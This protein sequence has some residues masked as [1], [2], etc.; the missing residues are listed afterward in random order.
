MTD[1]GLYVVDQETGELRAPGC[2]GCHDLANKLAARER[3]IDAEREEITRL[4]RKIKALETDKEAKMRRDKLFLAAQELFDEWRTECGHP[5]AE[6][7][8]ARIRLALAAVRRYG[9]HR[10]KLSWVI[11]AGKHLAYVNEQGEKQ[12][13]FGLLFRD[14]EHIEMYA[15]KWARWLKRQ[16]AAA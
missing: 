5:N 3:D 14:S 11:Q 6:F 10:E 7:D 1:H 15:N 12:D 9:K 4:R 13:R 2:N 8:A 16:G